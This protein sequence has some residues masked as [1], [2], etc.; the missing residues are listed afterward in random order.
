[1]AT[2]KISLLVEVGNLQ[3]DFYAR[4]DLE[5]CDFLQELCGADESD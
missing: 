1:M 4:V 3:L 5:I 2:V